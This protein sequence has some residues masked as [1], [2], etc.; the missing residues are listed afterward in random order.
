MSD[1]LDRCFEATEL[2]GLPL[3]NRL[4]KAATF[5]GK[6]PAGIPG[7]SLTR[8]HRRIAEG[9]VGLTTI[10][11]C[12]AE[13]DGRLNEN[14]LY[15]HEGIREPLEGLIR[16]LH[17]TG[18]KVS[19]QLG[20]CG[21][22]TKNRS[23]AGKRP[24]GPSRGF[25][26]LGLAYGLPFAD[27]MTTLQIRDRVAVFG[28]AARFMKS[29]GFDAIE[30]HFGHGYGISQFIS[31]KTNKR[32]DRYGGS[33]HNRMRFALEVLESV[34]RA[35]GED[36]PLLGKISMSDG[37]D[38][39]TTYEDSLEIASLLESAGIDVIICSGGIE[40]VV[41]GGTQGYETIS[42]FGIRAM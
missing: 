42:P 11:Y 12:A 16:T 10:A 14:M 18:A 1:P 25:N 27:A 29:V 41:G 2:N 15:M 19:G 28:N 36:F 3:R 33:L 20:H 22:F 31:P 35:V 5:E 21:S 6:T 30:I 17:E 7:E 34:R 9:G 8:F 37:V 39:G 13:A 40:C 4:L 38:G 32:K 24:T 23:F 26:A